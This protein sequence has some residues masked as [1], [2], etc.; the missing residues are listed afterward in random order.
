MKKLLSLLIVLSVVL[1]PNV[2]AANVLTVE[3]TESTSGEV[4]VSGTTESA[5]MAVAINIYDENGAL[6]AVRSTQ[7]TDEDKFEFAETF[8]AKKYTIKVA[9]YIG[10]TT[11]DV[12]VDPNGE[13]ATK[14]ETVT[15]VATYDPIY[16]SF[17]ILGL[18]L[19]GIIGGAVYFKKSKQ[20]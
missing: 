1:L 3:A 12:V 11:V 19:V 17:A 6:V 13:V 10:G 18:S 7:V 9:D 2:F 4:K 5:V 14:T 16:I 8:D 20:K 15:N